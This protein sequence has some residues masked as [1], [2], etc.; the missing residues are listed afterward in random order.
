M[1]RNQRRE[2]PEEREEE[3]RRFA[4]AECYDE[5]RPISFTFAKVKTQTCEGKFSKGGTISCPLFL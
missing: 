3:R 2:R 5:I 4:M 1:A